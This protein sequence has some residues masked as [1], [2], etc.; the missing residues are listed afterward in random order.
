MKKLKIG[1]LICSLVIILLAGC[2][3]KPCPDC[4][5]NFH[6]VNENIFRSAQPDEDE[7]E[8]LHTIY[9]IRSVLNLRDSSRDRKIIDIINRKHLSPVITLYDFPLD[10]GNI[11]ADE[12]YKILT[13]IRDAPKPL[14]VHCW[15]GS[16]RTGCVIAACRIVFENWSVED[17]IA[18]LEKPEYGHYKIFYSN[19]PALL[20]KTDWEKLKAEINVQQKD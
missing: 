15:L 3:S 18:E 8:S 19:I 20:R 1:S 11:S 4:P 2:N 6:K 5:R 10:T 13:V 14:L 12:L 17:A 9:G 16:N 7:F